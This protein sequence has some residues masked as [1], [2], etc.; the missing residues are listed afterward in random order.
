[1]LQGLLRFALGKSQRDIDG[2]LR[3]LVSMA[4]KDVPVYR[5]LWAESYRSLATFRGVCNL[6][7]LPISMRDELFLERATN[8]GISRRA[9]LARCKEVLTSGTQGIP[10]K[11]HMSQSEAFFRKLQLL[12]AW[13]KATPLR[14]PLTVVDLGARLD[15]REGVTSRW[16]GAV[17]L[18]RVPLM[19]LSSEGLRTLHRCRKAILSGYPS[20]LAWF[21]EQLGSRASE[22]Q[23]KMIA[24]R[25]EI[26]HDEVR[27]ALESGF[28]C[29]VFDFYNCE[30]IGNIAWQC[31]ADS[32]KMHINTDSCVVEVV[33]SDGTQLRQGELGR[34]VV[35]NLYNWTMPLIRYDLQDRGML[36]SS[37]GDR[38]ACGSC[39][40]TMGI[41]EGRDDDFLLL[42]DGEQVSPRLVATGFDREVERSRTPGYQGP[43]HRGYQII[44]DAPNHLTVRVVPVVGMG[45]PFEPQVREAFG[46]IAPGLQCDV[47]AVETLRSSKVEKLRKVVRQFEVSSVLEPDPS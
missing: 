36:L 43:L 24:T 19:S 40:P 1:L 18:V 38:C 11:V 13:G 15:P 7:E 47:V 8:E 41:V 27:R 14:F 20:S 39:S 3:S 30:E 16:Q 35:T 32:S 45:L 2:V 10:V 25:G 33:D 26:L 17:H 21:G 9:G 46:R 6:P 5:E 42:G 23:P 22:L 44:Q 28:G 29:P 34:I 37:Q 4:Y 12:R 31:P